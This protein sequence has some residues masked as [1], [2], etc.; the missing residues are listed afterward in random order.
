MQTET[1][2]FRVRYADT[3]AEAVAYYASYFTWFEVG[4]IHLLETLGLSLPDL[5]A[6]GRV[7]VASESF[8]KYR[9]P[10]RYD[11]LI[12]VR[13]RVA[14]AAPKRAVIEHQVVRHAD[15]EVL[16]HG[17]VSRVLAGLPDDGAWERA[18]ALPMPESVLDAAA[19]RVERIEPLS[20]R[21]EQLLAPTPPGARSHTAEFRVRY[22][23]TDAQGIAYFGSYYA[24]FEAGRTELGHAVGM[25]Y[26][27]LERRGYVLP[28]AEAFCRYFA[29]LR[30]CE[31]FRITTAVP[32][33]GKARITFTSRLAS[34][35]GQR[36]IAAG[37][38]LHALTQRDGR[39]QGLPPEI[40]QHYGPSA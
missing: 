19:E 35:D 12:V 13:S 14:R 39:P 10:A 21:A 33:L 25:P 36:E 4:L 18:I 32:A 23:E 17:A 34:P 6:Q 37:Y 30:P 38:T 7:L 29:P 8:A 1:P 9:R 3:D 2:P 16:A 15:G 28:V 40:V 11:E 24:W 27:E 22:A 20:R 5:E 31:R 26:S